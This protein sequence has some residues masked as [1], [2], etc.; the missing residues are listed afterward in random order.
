MYAIVNIA[1]QQFRVENNKKI[2][3]HRLEA[4]EGSSLEFNEILLL[5]EDGQVL[6]GKPYLEGASVVAKV[7]EHMK[8]DKVLVFKKKRRKGYQKMNGHRQYMTK[9][10]IEGIFK[11]GTPAKK[12]TKKKMMKEDIPESETTPDI[13]AD[14]VE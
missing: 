5:E 3:V 8:A 10:E 2:F 4:E 14:S 6:I 13:Q 12:T 11:Q 1:G 9:I 7:V